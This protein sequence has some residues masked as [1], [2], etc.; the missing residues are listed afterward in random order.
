MPVQWGIEAV[1]VKYYPRERKFIKT[2]IEHPNLIA[3][4]IIFY[5]ESKL[6]GLL[7]LEG[8]LCLFLFY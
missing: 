1:N 7:L 3:S 2:V 4:S 8:E 5:L 6:A